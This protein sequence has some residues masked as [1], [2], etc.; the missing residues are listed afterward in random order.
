[1]QN[2]SATASS[3]S[4]HSI[5]SKMSGRSS[6]SPPVKM[7]SDR[8]ELLR[9]AYH[10]F[11]VVRAELRFAGSLVPGGAAVDAVGLAARGDLKRADGRLGVAVEFDRQPASEKL[12][13]C[14]GR[15]GRLIGRVYE[16]ISLTLT[17][18]LGERVRVRRRMIGLP[19]PRTAFWTPWTA[20]FALGK[21]A[22]RA[23]RASRKTSHRARPRWS[24]REAPSPRRR[25]PGKRAQGLQDRVVLHPGAQ[26]ARQWA[27][28]PRWV[29]GCDRQEP[30]ML[31]A[32]ATC[33]LLGLFQMYI[34]SSR[35][36][37]LNLASI[38]HCA[39]IWDRIM[40]MQTFLPYPD[41]EKTARVLDSRRLGKQ[42]AE[43]LTIIRC[44]VSP[45]AG[46]TI[47][48]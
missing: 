39:R 3:L 12:H 11:P 8:A 19:L 13:G 29:A 16:Q 18:S 6:G 17:L 21:P 20:R 2:I 31:F 22:E 45:T 24:C 42:R 28:E 27:G 5:S 10:A 36:C 4:T 37:K 35:P 43:A 15:N 9:L 25:Q 1:M 14:P 30:E 46:C 26:D 48:P 47:P 33:L 41:F 23:G 32:H 7:I 44:L 34:T 40:R 38:R